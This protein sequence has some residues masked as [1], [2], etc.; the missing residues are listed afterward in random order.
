MTSSIKILCTNAHQ[1]PTQ[2]N[3]ATYP[4]RSVLIDHFRWSVALNHCPIH[5]SA[6]L[7]GHFNFIKINCD[8]HKVCCT[9]ILYVGFCWCLFYHNWF[10]FIMSGLSTFRFSNYWFVE[11]YACSF[12]TSVN[13]L[14]NNF[15]F[16]WNSFNLKFFKIKL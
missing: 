2:I 1:T 12:I 3:F 13:H 14:S 11:S 6:P 16:L 10:I 8:L 15:F 4:E 5:L 9:R 7:I